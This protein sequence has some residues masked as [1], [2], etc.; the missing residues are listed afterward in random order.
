[1]LHKTKQIFAEFTGSSKRYPRAILSETQAIKIYS[2]RK[3]KASCCRKTDPLLFGRSAAVATKFNVSP[4]AIRDI[5]NRRTWTQETRHLW[6][7]DEQPMFRMEK[8]MH[9]RTRTCVMPRKYLQLTRPSNLPS[10][11]SPGSVVDSCKIW[12]DYPH[13]ANSCSF[14]NHDSEQQSHFHSRSLWPPLLLTSSIPCA[15]ALS[16]TP[17]SSATQPLRSLSPPPPSGPDVS[18]GAPLYTAPVSA[19][20]AWAGAETRSDGN[21]TGRSDSAEQSEGGQVGAELA[22]GPDPF[23]LDWPTWW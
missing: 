15:D 17:Q 20:C 19:G 9:K 7:K 12:P 23:L 8:R 2:Y 4:K 18:A 14:Y 16:I 21:R 22:P 3:T 13:F 10:T 5:W 1:M 6:T 11:N